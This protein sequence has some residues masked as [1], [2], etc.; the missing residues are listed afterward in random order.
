[1][2]NKYKIPWHVRQFVKKELLDYKAN[3]KLIKNYKGDTRGFLIASTRICQ[4]DKVFNNLNSED[5]EIAELI[6]FEHYTQ[7]KAETTKHIPKSL[8]YTVMS[9]II[10]LTA[11]EMELI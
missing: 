7:A 10:Y 9:K 4:I 1:M 6:F 3:K 5:K 8:Y 2:K 11:Q